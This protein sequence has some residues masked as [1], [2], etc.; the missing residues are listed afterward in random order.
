MP[1]FARLLTRQQVTELAAYIRARN[2]NEPPFK[3]LTDTVK[4]L[5]DRAGMP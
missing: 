2:S 3:D 4:E 5:A 1:G